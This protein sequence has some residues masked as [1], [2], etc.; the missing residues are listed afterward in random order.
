MLADTHANMATLWAGIDRP[1]DALA[2]SR[3]AVAIREK[4]VAELPPV[5]DL[6]RAL[7]DD[8]SALAV[9]FAG[10]GDRVEA[11]RQHRKAVAVREGLLAESPDRSELQAGLAASY[12]YLGRF[13]YERGQWEKSGEWFGK[14][15]GCFTRVCQ[16]LPEDETA[17]RSLRAAH[18]GRAAASDQL[19]MFEDADKSWSKALAGAFD[20]E[21]RTVRADRANSRAKAG[22]IKD[23]LAEV[24]DL[25][26]VPDDDADRL[27]LYAAVY[28]L[29]SAKVAEKKQE[30]ATQ[31][32]E[33]LVKAVKPVKPVKAG[34]TDAAHISKNT[35]FDPIRERADFKKLVAELEKMVTPEPKK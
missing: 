20:Q 17:A 15:V 27:Y 24:E 11:A 1:V 19:K 3:Q 8:H 10:T 2:H 4:L 22:K 5:S 18:W 26:S 29:A 16:T 25:R 13:E 9:L 7:G 6:Q 30:Y 12:F 14:A 23:A 31:A 34:Y 35:D 28:S 33:L 21:A 32:M